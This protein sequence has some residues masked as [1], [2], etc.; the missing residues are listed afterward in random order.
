MHRKISYEEIKP[1]LKG[2]EN[3]NEFLEAD[4]LYMFVVG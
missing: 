1:L 3:S 2:V 4:F